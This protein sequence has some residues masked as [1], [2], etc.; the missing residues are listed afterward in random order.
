MRRERI[1][2]REDV[3]YVE[4]DQNNNKIIPNIGLLSNGSGMALATVDYL[5]EINGKVI[6]FADVGGTFVME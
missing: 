2:I 3:K 4:L 6:N 5:T 1:T